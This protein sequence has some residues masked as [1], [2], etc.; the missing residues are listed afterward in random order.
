MCDTNFWLIPGP[1][2]EGRVSVTALPNRQFRV[3]ALHPF[4]AVGGQTWPN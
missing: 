4:H 2:E 3:S 1:I